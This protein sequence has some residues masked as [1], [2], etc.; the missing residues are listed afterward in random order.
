MVKTLETNLAEREGMIRI[1]Q[2]TK[3][4]NNSNDILNKVAAGQA[5]MMAAAQAAAATSGS[6]TV[7]PPAAS[8]VAAAAAAAAAAADP[9]TLTQ[10]QI[11]QL[12]AAQHLSLLSGAA[13]GGAL[14][15]VASGAPNVGQY[16]HQKQLSTPL[17]LSS[18]SGGGLMSLPN[19]QHQ[20]FKSISLNS[21]PTRNLTSLPYGSPHGATSSAITGGGGLQHGP[22]PSL[23][24]Y[25]GRSLTPSADMLL[26]RSSEAAAATA[27]AAAAFRSSTPGV[28]FFQSPSSRLTGLDHLKLVHPSLRRESA[29]AD[30]LSNSP[31]I[32]SQ[33]TASIAP[34]LLLGS[35]RATNK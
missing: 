33:S 15:Q 9:M 29:P 1:L 5:A 35:N 32:S 31:N 12:G 6:H 8:A 21:T 3:T 25:H 20:Q 23:A 7:I 34:S 10:A 2:T 30:V 4:V 11:K 13:G 27:A 24:L 22:A 26:L 18:S 19:P 17:P 16:H 28:D 14:G